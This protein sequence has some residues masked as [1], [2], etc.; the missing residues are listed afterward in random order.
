MNRALQLAKVG[1]LLVTTLLAA[2]AFLPEYRGTALRLWVLAAGTLILGGLLGAL[3]ARHPTRPSAFDQALRRRPRG[4]ERPGDLARIEREV[5]LAATSAGDVHFR[6]RPRVRAVAAHRLSARRGI[7]LDAEPG[8]ARAALAPAVWELVRPD[9][10]EP[11]DRFA[12]GIGRDQ[13]RAVVDG[14]DTI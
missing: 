8:A 11:S 13:L 14:L 7:D 1:S 10:A 9:R 2:L 12:P 5:A 4:P 3:R 6:L